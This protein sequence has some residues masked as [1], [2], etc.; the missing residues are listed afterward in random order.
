MN[1]AKFIATV[2]SDIDNEIDKWF[3]IFK[4]NLNK[5]VAQKGNLQDEENNI[6]RSSSLLCALLR[7]RFALNIAKFELYTNRNIFTTNNKSDSCSSLSLDDLR[8]KYVQLQNREAEL[9]IELAHSQEYVEHL[10]KIVQELN[11]GFNELSANGNKS[12]ADSIAAQKL[13]LEK[14]KDLSSMAKGNIL[15]MVFL[16]CYNQLL[17]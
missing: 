6:L 17:C 4:D 12:L 1:S 5:L 3:G 14:L 8:T 16:V 2:K 7:E 9:T 13:Q 15:C 10:R 11:E